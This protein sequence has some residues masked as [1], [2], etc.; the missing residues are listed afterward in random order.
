MASIAKMSVQMGWNGEEAE[1]GAASMTKTLQKVES[2]ANS[3]NDKMKEMGKPDSKEEAIF[4]NKLA[5]QGRHSQ[6]KEDKRKRNV[7]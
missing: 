2:A 7:C 6:R 5:N 3:S 4:Q 1:K